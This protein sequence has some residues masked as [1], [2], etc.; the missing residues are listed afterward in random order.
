[1]KFEWDTQKSDA[2][3]ADRGFDFAYVTRAFLDPLRVIRHDD[4]HDYG[5]KR[6][7]L[8]GQIDSRLFCLAY[9][10]RGGVI[11]IISA[12]KANSREVKKYANNQHDR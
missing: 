4:R 5:E 10:V 11:R 12:R 8:M 1:M 2:C 7:T 9:T 3:Y 6:Y